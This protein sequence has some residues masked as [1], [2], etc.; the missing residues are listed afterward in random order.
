MV[1]RR[2]SVLDAIQAFNM[3]YDTTAKIGQEVELGRI[4]SAAPEDVTVSTPSFSGMTGS[5][6]EQDA[7]VAQSKGVKFLGKTYDTAPTDAQMNSARTMAMAGVLKKS[8]PLQGFQ[9]EQQAMQG[10]R[11]EDRYQRE[12]DYR[13]GR[14]DLFSNTRFGQN[15]RQYNDAMADYK[16]KLG[17]YEGAKAS[18]KTGLD[19]GIAP[20]APTRPDYSVGDSLADRATLISHDAKHGKLDARTFG[21]FTDMLSKVQNEGY[22]KT[23]RL[24][25]SGAPIQEVIKSFNSTGNAQVDANNVV[26]DKMVKGKGGVETRVIQIKDQN[27]NI[28]TINTVAELDSLGKANDVFTRFYQGEHLALDKQRTDANVAHTVAQTGVINQTLTEKKELDTIRTGL[29]KAI[30]DGDEAA[31]KTGRAQMMSYMMSGKSGTQ[32]MSS[33]ERKANFY[34]ASGMAKTSDEA[35]RMAH[36]KVQTSAKD[37]YMSLMKPNSMGMVPRTE[38]IE[39]VM[40]AMHGTNWK[41]KLSGKSATATPGKSLDFVSEADAQQAAKDGKIKK[42]D[43]ITIGGKVGTWQ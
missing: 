9:L 19:L 16:K 20:V 40:Q 22:E 15:Q 28:K 10:Q 8:N 2:N 14:Q 12:E 34:L 18:G 31:I 13:K 26:S 21:E 39:P 37:D 4:A 38:D 17:D 35:A 27:G 42:G 29:N 6:D 41:D 7:N 23:L 3:A 43:R 24:A 33:E 36:E 1:R 5:Y 11:E 25:Q 32:N 30:S